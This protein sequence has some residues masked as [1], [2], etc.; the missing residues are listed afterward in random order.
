MEGMRLFSL[1]ELRARGLKDGVGLF[2]QGVETPTKQP[3]LTAEASKIVADDLKRS[4]F[5]PLCSCWGLSKWSL[6]V[7]QMGPLSMALARSSQYL[8]VWGGAL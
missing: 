7:S 3:Q 5:F 8:A 1:D 4:M 2:E 6:C